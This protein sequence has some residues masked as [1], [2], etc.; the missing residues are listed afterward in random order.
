VRDGAV[1]RHERVEALVRQRGQGRVAVSG[2][3]S[4]LS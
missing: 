2:H 3:W 4:S 1:E